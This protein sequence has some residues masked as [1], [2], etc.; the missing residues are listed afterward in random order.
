MKRRITR[1][2]FG[3][4]VLLLA[5]LA[6]SLPGLSAPTPFVFPTP[7]LTMTAIFNPTLDPNVT[8]TSPPPLATTTPSPTIGNPTSDTPAPEASE[9]PA[10]TLTSTFSVPTSEPTSTPAATRSSGGPGMRPN[11]SVAGIYFDSPPE[12]DGR[13]A[14]WDMDTYALDNVVY[15]GERRNNPA[16]LSGSMMVGWDEDN[17]YIAVRVR[18]DTYV[19]EE[20]GVFLFRGDSLEVLLDT[21]VSVDF[22]VRSL[23]AD[24]YQLGIS[25]GSPSLGKDAEAYLWYPE[26]IEGPL[27]RVRVGTQE[28]DDG[29]RVEAAIPWSIFDLDPEEGMHFGFASSISDNDRE[30]EAVQQSMVSNVPTRRL[31]DPTTWGDLTLIDP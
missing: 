28:V 21:D 25:P 14:D 16:D 3:L 6:C 29:Y 19:Q 22:Y 15:G 9:T 23:S 27:S 18:D 5:T 2:F 10:A 12:I 24:D 7:D 26:S 4:T 13:F 1:P 30:G 8:F 17:L 31:T 11:Y 20:S